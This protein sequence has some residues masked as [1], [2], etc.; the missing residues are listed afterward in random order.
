M[1]DTSTQRCTCGESSVPPPAGGHHS[2]YELQT[3]REFFSG[4]TPDYSTALDRIATALEKIADEMVEVEAT[5]SGVRKELSMIRQ[6][7]TY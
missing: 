2:W 3:P 1:M 6:K 4:L 7:R 5:L